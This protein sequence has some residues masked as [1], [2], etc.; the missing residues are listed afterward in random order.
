MGIKIPLIVGIVLLV[1]VVLLFGLEEPIEVKEGISQKTVRILTPTETILVP[2]IHTSE[3][4]EIKSSSIVEKISEPSLSTQSFPFEAYAIID[5]AVDQI[6]FLRYNVFPDIGVRQH[7]FDSNHNFF[8]TKF[9]EVIN[10]DRGTGI[11]TI[12]TIPALGKER[13]FGS[14]TDSAGNY[15]FGQDNSILT[16]LVPSTDTF[17][18]V[19]LKLPGTS[20]EFQYDTLE[21]SSSGEVLFMDR[22]FAGKVNFD[23]GD[24]T[25]WD[26][27][28]TVNDMVLDSN[29]NMYY[30]E[31]HSTGQKLYRLNP[32]TNVL[33]TWF[34]DSVRNEPQAVTIDNNDNIYIYVKGDTRARIQKIDTT[35]N[36]FEEWIV[37]IEASIIARSM[38]VDSAGTVYFLDNLTRFVPST[39]KFTTWD[40]EA[41]NR[42]VHVT[43][44]SNDDL[45]ISGQGF[46]GKITAP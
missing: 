20:F 27:P 40:I 18:Q 25:I 39:G 41:R 26:Q 21:I 11:K 44:D 5:S 4:K 24:V 16:K 28:L 19:L 32:T 34:L 42:L 15:Y 22:T 7:A 45:W 30:V 10:Y 43:L 8:T 2:E 46:F 37:P 38:A 14:T 3:I 17:I 33:T 36:V 13:G 12:W 29:D 31:L 1:S 6:D 35:T 9:N 23:T